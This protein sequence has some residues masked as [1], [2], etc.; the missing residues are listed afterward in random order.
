MLN[1]FLPNVFRKSYLNF[2]SF[3]SD[4]WY[5]HWNYCS[6]NTTARWSYMCYTV[7]AVGLA[8]QGAM[9]RQSW[10]WLISPGNFQLQR[11]QGLDRISS[12]SDVCLVASI[13][14]LNKMNEYSTITEH[15]LQLRNATKH[16][17]NSSKVL[18]SILIQ[19]RSSVF[20]GHFNIK[21]PFYQYMCPYSKHTTFSRP[22]FYQWNPYTWENRSL[23]K[24]NTNSRHRIRKC[25]FFVVSL[26][27][28]AYNFMLQH[29]YVW[30]TLC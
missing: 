22:C 4:E 18:V 23:L 8:T 16:I 30:K 11:G 26:L 25:I 17:I 24:R 28:A 14:S 29:Q 1:H 2:L 3:R 20:R 19:I 12:L 15:F 13:Y 21:I 6:W 9:H 27:L 5:R 7:S 10:Y